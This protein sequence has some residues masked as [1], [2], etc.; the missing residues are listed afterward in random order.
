[1]PTFG[2]EARFTRDWAR[3]TR[4]QRARFLEVLPMFVAA[5]ALN[6]FP[7]GLRVKRLKSAPDVWEMSFGPDE[8]ATFEFGPPVRPGERHVI[9]RRIGSHDIFREP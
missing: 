7:A 6:T 1:M 4:A 2:R 9:W 3:L 8:R 5:V